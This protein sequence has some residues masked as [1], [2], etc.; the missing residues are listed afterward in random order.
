MNYLKK[1]LLSSILVL[2]AISIHPAAPADAGDR[3]LVV[4]ASQESMSAAA[5]EKSDKEHFKIESFYATKLQFIQEN[6]PNGL[7]YFDRDILMF[8]GTELDNVAVLPQDKE[9]FEIKLWKIF[10]D[11]YSDVFKP[12]YLYFA[13]R[14]AQ[15]SIEPFIVDKLKLVEN[16][17]YIEILKKALKECAL[18]GVLEYEQSIDALAFKSK[19]ILVKK[20]GKSL[21]AY[22]ESEFE[23]YGLR[24]SRHSPGKEPKWVAA[25][26][27]KNP[28]EVYKDP[29]FL[30]KLYLPKVLSRAAYDITQASDMSMHGT[31][32][33][34]DD[35][36]DSMEEI[37]NKL[38]LSAWYKDFYADMLKDIYKEFNKF[39][40]RH[41][42][43]W[44]EEKLLELFSD[45]FETYPNNIFHVNEAGELATTREFGQFFLHNVMHNINKWVE[46]LKKTDS[47]KYS[48]LPMFAR[49]VES[50]E[51]AQK[52]EK[53]CQLRAFSQL[54]AFN[55]QSERLQKDAIESWIKIL[56]DE[57]R[58]RHQLNRLHE[59]K[60]KA[61]RKKEAEEQ[62]QRDFDFMR[63]RETQERAQTEKRVQF[64]FKFLAEREA[65]EKDAQ[66]E[67]Q[68][69][70]AQERAQ[71][72]QGVLDE[73]LPPLAL[74]EAKK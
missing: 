58:E 65:L 41:G 50:L 37:K 18:E 31:K 54:R 51:L 29:S 21:D 14:I 3:E 64:D 32:P 71:W 44:N 56:N 74:T 59:A 61:L 69:L 8:L 62:A 38:I 52:Q 22:M 16:G 26:I 5:A 67:F 46:E 33:K 39:D 17:L 24:Y 45:T 25:Y 35:D 28:K 1:Y 42:T 7:P 63:Q 43:N 2:T 19:R 34:S 40:R 4:Q 15:D 10:L 47:D 27:T 36:C 60:Y 23:K 55:R 13:A 70:L 72:A 6:M 20:I 68:W 53:A 12:S 48:K 49:K 9:L 66:G 11:V 30:T 73:F 57:Q